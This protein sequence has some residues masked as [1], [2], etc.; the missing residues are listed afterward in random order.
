M[1]LR[2]LS[3]IFTSI[4]LLGCISE[5]QRNLDQN[6]NLLKSKSALSSNSV[7]Y[8]NQE[9]RISVLNELYRVIKDRYALWEIK[10]LNIGVDGDQLFQAAITHEKN[11]Q[12]VE[13]PFEQAKAN[14]KFLDRTKA[15]IA[16][17]QDT[18]F[19]ARSN[20]ATPMIMNGLHTK[21]AFRDGNKDQPMVVVAGIYKKIMN[22]NEALADHKKYKEIKKGMEVVSIDGTPI[23]Q[24]VADME[25]YVA[26]SSPMFRTSRAAQ[27]LSR[28]NLDYP[29]KNYVDI[30]LKGKEKTL[31]VRL[32]WYVDSTKRVDAKLYFDE[33]NFKELTQVHFSWDEEKQ[34]WNED[35]SL[36]YDGHHYSDAPRGLINSKEYS[37]SSRLVVR[38]GYFL[39]SGKAYGYIQFFAFTNN[40]ISL[41]DSEDKTT[42][43]EVFKDFVVELK[44]NETPLIVDIRTNFGG[45]TSIAIDNLS[46]IGKLGDAY[47]SRT[48]NYK[49]TRNIWSLL[50][51]I[52]LDPSLV[53]IADRD[54]TDLFLNVF[55]QAAKEG[56]A[57][58]DIILFTDPIE[59]DEDVGGYDQ[60]VVALV[61]P[62]CISACDNQS[63][64]FK[65]SE[66]VTLIGQPANGTGAGFYSLDSHSSYFTDSY[67]IVKTRIP[68]YLFGLPVKTEKRVLGIG[69]NMSLL[70]STNSEN[71]PTEPQIDF[72]HSPQSFQNKDE[73]WINKAIEVLEEKQSPNS[74]I[75]SE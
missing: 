11:I 31:K 19:R 71:K 30:E 69:E 38:T 27:Y 63:F 12:N 2:V 43:R 60:D 7:Y 41:P 70:L 5:N 15:L 13:T 39:K 68:N 65:S 48:I 9:D 73:E 54:D 55:D 74:L 23:L 40:K 33:L 37:D 61:G 49:I 75:A 67:F 45:S 35:E 21:I 64:L 44:E 62:W 34:K 51:S 10:K 58:S 29:E 53:D 36:E 25:K 50:N 52:D 8:Y 3:V 17:F 26:A 56:R 59:A 16:H 28:R 66:R 47:P 32:P 24:A 46:A 57:Y 6:S 20:V 42:L 22:M 18:H 4:F 72:F 14:L 1:N